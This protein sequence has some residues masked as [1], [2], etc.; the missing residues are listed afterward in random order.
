M[1]PYI[2]QSVGVCVSVHACVCVY[3]PVAAKN[4]EHKEIYSWFNTLDKIDL[5]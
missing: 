2:I 5:G 4:Q 3:L 1:Y